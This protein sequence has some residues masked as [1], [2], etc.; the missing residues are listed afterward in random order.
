MKVHKDLSDECLGWLYQ[1]AEKYLDYYKK[2]QYRTK[3][4][5]DSMYYLK[6][7]EYYQDIIM[8]IKEIKYTKQL[9]TKK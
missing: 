4:I 7:V 9:K 1:H 8:D 2:C 6:Y 3:I 5:E